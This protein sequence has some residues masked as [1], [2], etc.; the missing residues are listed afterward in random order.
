MPL[1]K[2]AR[3]TGWECALRSLSGRLVFLDYAQLSAETR[4]KTENQA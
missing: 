4:G 2:V 1:R 3:K